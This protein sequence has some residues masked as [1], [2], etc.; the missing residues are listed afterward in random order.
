MKHGTVTDEFDRAADAYD[1]LV[2][3]NPGYHAHLRVSARRLGA[4][5]LGPRP[6]VLDLGCGTGAS[7]AALLETVPSA[8]IA[9][10]DASQGMLERARAKDWPSSVSFH[11]ARAEELTPAWAERELGGP[12][13]AVFGAYLLRNCPDPDALLETAVSL[14]RPGGRLVLHEYSVADSAAARAV[15]TAVCWSV[16][17]PAGRTLTGRADLFRYL[18]RSVLEFDGRREVLARMRRAGLECVA[19]APLPGWQY[20]ITHTFAGKRSEEAG[21]GS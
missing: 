21:D 17:I 2:A 4:D 1:R 15:W 10:V 18:W 14:L 12:A 11:R 20:G 16:V 9:G 19:S 3:A 13:D 8:R 6:R 7:T 5:S